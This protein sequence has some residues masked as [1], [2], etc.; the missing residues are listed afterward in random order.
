LTNVTVVTALF[1]IGRD[2]CKGY[3]KRNFDQYTGWFRNLLPLNIPMVIYCEP[4]TEELVWQYRS[5]ENTKVILMTTQ[6]IV[7]Y[8]PYYQ[9]VQDI[10]NQ[11][12]WFDGAE[13]LPNSPQATLRLYNP[14]VMSKLYWMRDVAKENYFKTDYF[15]WIDGGIANTTPIS[16]FDPPFFDQ[17]ATYLD[18]FL[19]LCFDY[20][21]LEVHGFETDA[22]DEYAQE[23]VN[24]V[25][26]AT[27]FGGSAAV[28]EEMTDLYDD[29]LCV[30]LRNGY[31]GTEESI[32]TLLTYLYPEKCH[33]ESLGDRS[34]IY[35]F[36]DMLKRRAYEFQT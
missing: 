15:L 18:K 17:I 9:E 13:W 23:K 4:F 31:M 27:L 8:F 24:R 6:D 22:M 21:D 12:A 11:S 7:E 36:L 16:Y 26:R 30:T 32:F 14:L 25:A 5:K 34:I 33:I 1:D 28:L 29:L 35:P 20:R 19:L 2:T 3:F 10:R